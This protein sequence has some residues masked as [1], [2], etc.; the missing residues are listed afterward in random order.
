MPTSK[1]NHELLSKSEIAKALGMTSQTFSNRQTRDPKFPAPTYSNRSGSVALYAP[2]D[3]K[4]VYDYC[5]RAERERLEKAEKMFASLT[6]GEVSFED[7][8][9]PLADEDA[10]QEFEDAAPAAAPAPEK[11][12]AKPEPVK[13]DPA[14]KAKADAEKAA[15]EKATADKIKAADAKIAADK[16]KTAPA[17]TEAP[18]A[19]APASKPATPATPSK[20][21]AGSSFIK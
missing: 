6:T 4:K 20:A 21:P 14:A 9:L 3:A 19:S 16:A 12:E 13:E 8:E 7:V 5:T 18:K 17:K 10:D 2:E 1:K 15:K 11:V